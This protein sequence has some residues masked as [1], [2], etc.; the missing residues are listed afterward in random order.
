MKRSKVIRVIILVESAINTF[1]LISVC[2][3]AWRFHCVGIIIFGTIV[4]S[5]LP[6]YSPSNYGWQKQNREEEK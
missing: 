3:Q 4:E 1:A 6:L 5:C 2:S